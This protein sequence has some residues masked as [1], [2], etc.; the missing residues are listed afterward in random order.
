MNY[1]ENFLNNNELMPINNQKEETN[2]IN[3]DD[4]I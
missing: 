4:L 2:I 3:D 1:D